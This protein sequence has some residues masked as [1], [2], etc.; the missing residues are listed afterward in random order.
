M[1]PRRWMAIGAAIA[2]FVAGGCASAARWPW[3]RPNP[4][5]VLVLNMHAG[6]D[7]QG[8]DN[9]E[10]V[11]DLVKTTRADLVL[12]Q[13]VDRGTARSGQVDQID[14]L[15]SSTRYPP[16]FAASLISYQ[17]G[18]YGIAALAREM[19]GYQVTVPLAVTPVQTRAGGSREPRVALLG[20]ATVR[21]VPW[22][23]LN[24]HVDPSDA[25]ARTQELRQVAAAAR[26][27]MAGRPLVVGG[28]LN[29]T[30]DDPG[31]AAFRDAGLRDAWLECG[32][33]GGFTYPSDKPVKRIDYLWL[34][35]TLA[36]ASATVVDTALSDHRPLLV[37]LK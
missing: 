37:T 32:S 36:C 19:V 2:L 9:L 21:G 26:E 27:Q 8:A 5:R 16:A 35:G 13:E 10:R 31:L 3:S 14:R 18:Q 1:K 25:A 20:Y 6:K 29:A 15:A 17:G 22:R 33:G 30:P 11:A 34:A 28:D 23:F 12:L 7:A 24:T 4:I